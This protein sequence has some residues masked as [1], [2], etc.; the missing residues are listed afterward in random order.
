MSEV[1]V[2]A[3]RENPLAGQRERRSETQRGRSHAARNVVD[4]EVLKR[5]RK[6]ER[7]ERLERELRELK[8]MQA[9]CDQQRS[10]RHKSRSHSGSCE[11]SHRFPKQSR[12]DHRAQKSSR[13]SRPEGKTRKTSPVRK[14]EEKDHN[15]VWNQLRKIS[16]S[17]FSSRIERAK[18]PAR[19]AH[20]NLITYNGKT[21]PVARLSHYRRSMALHN[22][23]DIL[24]CRIFPSS[25]GNV[26]LRL[27]DRLKH[28]SIHS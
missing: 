17:P 19:I 8:E 27:F 13:R 3:N 22:G 26:A 14:Q 11:S 7:L 2:E 25:L 16:H 18:L 5:S 1:H 6:I 12:E 21:D 28:G 10:G 20:F 15:P 24:M 4:A 23:N 9:S